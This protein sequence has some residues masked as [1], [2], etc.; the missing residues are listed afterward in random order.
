M[1][2]KLNLVDPARLEKA[3]ELFEE[4]LEIS[5]Y[6]DEIIERAFK[7]LPDHLTKYGLNE[8]DENFTR[9][10]DLIQAEA[11]LWDKE[12]AH[13]ELEYRYDGYEEPPGVLEDRMERDHERRYLNNLYK[14]GN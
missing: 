3:K 8:M 2:K 11:E 14:K 13:L 7:K 6:R 10:L 9:L 1:L 5:S 12:Q 4:F